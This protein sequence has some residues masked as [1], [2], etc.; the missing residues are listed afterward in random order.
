MCKTSVREPGPVA[1][2]L[3]DRTIVIPS[4]RRAS[5]KSPYRLYAT[6][7][8]LPLFNQIF[9]YFAY[10]FDSM[11][12]RR[13]NSRKTSPLSGKQVTVDLLSRRPVCL[14]QE[15]MVVYGD[16]G[17]VHKLIINKFPIHFR[18]GST[19]T[20]HTFPYKD[21][22]SANRK[23]QEHRAQAIAGKH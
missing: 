3:P 14:V 12:L 17:K 20:L 4:S 10:S 22:Q 11:R 19:H 8:P 2:S 23:R 15:W 1:R 16:D 13:S 9:A 21:G 6:G 7:N 5:N 18:A